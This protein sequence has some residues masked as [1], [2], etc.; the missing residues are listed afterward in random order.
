MSQDSTLTLPSRSLAGP[1]PVPGWECMVPTVSQAH[2]SAPPLWSC[3]RG[4]GGWEL[5]LPFPFGV[6]LWILL[7]KFW[8][9]F[10]LSTCE[11]S[12]W[13]WLRFLAA[14]SP[15]SSDSWL[16]APG[17]SQGPFPP[18]P[19]LSLPRSHKHFPFAHPAPPSLR[20]P[21]V[22]GPISV[23]PWPHL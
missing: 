22:P 3:R 18:P 7:W 4:L 15:L 12:P 19:L 21:S 1:G 9:L 8:V 23:F 13:G 10:P 20:P 2:L 5:P 11:V 16:T 17:P 6:T 14:P